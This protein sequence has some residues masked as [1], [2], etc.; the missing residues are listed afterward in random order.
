ML[1][2]GSPFFLK[3][4]DFRLLPCLL[5]LI[6]QKALV[7]YDSIPEKIYRGLLL[8]FKKEGLFFQKKYLKDSQKIA[9]FSSSFDQ[10]KEVFFGALEDSFKNHS[11]IF[12]EEGVWGEEVFEKRV[13]RGSYR[14]GF[15]LYFLSSIIFTSFIL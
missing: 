3:N 6:G 15:R 8:F 5:P 10:Q 11:F 12:L 13:L 9:G 4:F 2:E 14:L 1:G 7:F